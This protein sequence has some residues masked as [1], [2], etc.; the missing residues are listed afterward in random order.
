MSLNNAYDFKTACEKADKEFNL[1]LNEKKTEE[2][3]KE[4]FEETK[5]EEVDVKSESS[6]NQTE[7]REG[8]PIDSKLEITI[9]ASNTEDSNSDSE[10]SI[11]LKTR[12]VK[13]FECKECDREFKHAGNFNVHNK[14]YHNG[15]LQ[16]RKEFKSRTEP[17]TTYKCET[18]NIT[19][20]RRTLYFNHM[21][22]HGYICTECGEKFDKNVRLTDHK[23]KVHGEA[24]Y[25]CTICFKS[26]KRAFILRNHIKSVHNKI[27]DYSCDICS[28][29]F[30]LKRQ[31]DYHNHQKHSGTVA[32]KDHKC[33]QCDKS[34]ATPSNLSK[35]KE[36]H[37]S[38]EERI[39]KKHYLCPHCGK[40][41]LTLAGYNSHVFAH[42]GERNFECTTCQKKFMVKNQLKIHMR[43]HTGERPFRCTH[44]GCE[45]G[46]ML[47]AHLKC[48]LLSHSGEKRFTCN[49]CGV[50][51]KY[52]D[53]LRHHMN[54]VHWGVR[55]YACDQCDDK[56]YTSNLLKQHKAKIHKVF[57]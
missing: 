5:I 56:F 41:L 30:I 57:A 54:N 36:I 32:T 28:K 48:H 2:S 4:E 26:F 55:N 14:L 37:I 15:E 27:K 1:I 13:I 34:F 35:H 40:T 16:A 24:K 31:L 11:T 7:L 50:S 44:P 25:E 9:A 10:T 12:T 19:F 46:Y 42:E 17:C 53:N 23:I 39:K 45:A 43:I 51:M 29:Q 18:C 52:K 33:D 3:V 49:V 8:T 6:E 21:D 22:T 20:K 47:L 38:E